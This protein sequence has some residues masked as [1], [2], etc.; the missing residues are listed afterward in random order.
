[1]QP[2]PLPTFSLEHVRNLID[3]AGS[4]ALEVGL[5]MAAAEQL[6]GVLLA[7]GVASAVLQTDDWDRKKDDWDVGDRVSVRYWSGKAGAFIS[8]F[9]NC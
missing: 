2:K 9:R 6:R 7:P 4:P 5:K 8:C 1:M 3:A